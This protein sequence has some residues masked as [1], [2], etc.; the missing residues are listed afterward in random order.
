MVK[1]SQ[2]LFYK[3]E[4]WHS[5]TSNA[6]QIGNKKMNKKKSKSVAII[7]K[8]LE[9]CVFV[10]HLVGANLLVFSLS[11]L[12]LL[13]LLYFDLGGVLRFFFLFAQF[14]N[15]NQKAETVFIF[16]P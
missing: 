7:I 10:L 15:A 16:G 9:E 8:L 2:S 11:L 12:M 3:N 5:K 6:G 1:P 4:T 13:L 14:R